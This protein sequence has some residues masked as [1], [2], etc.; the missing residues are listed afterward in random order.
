MISSKS[1]SNIVANL[2]ELGN[3][4]IMFHI[5]LI[6]TC[7]LPDQSSLQIPDPFLVFFTF[8]IQEVSRNANPDPKHCYEGGCNY[9]H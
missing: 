2:E 9:L 4:S 6:L 5:F 7:A 3:E 1:F 8:R